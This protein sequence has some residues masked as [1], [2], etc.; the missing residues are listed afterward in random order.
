MM[1]MMRQKEENL[2]ILQ[3]LG[4]R[5]YEYKNKYCE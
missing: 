2:A 5:A 4:Q 3:G 1:I